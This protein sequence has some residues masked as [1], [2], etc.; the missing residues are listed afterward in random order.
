MFSHIQNT[1]TQYNL[2]PYEKRIDQAKNRADL[3]DHFEDEDL[4]MTVA[5]DM[6]LLDSYDE[7]ID[8]LELYLENRAKVHDAATFYLL[9]SIPGIGKILSLTI[10]YEIHEISRFPS[11]GE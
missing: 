9:R 11:V 10:L 7:T 3:L 4:Q 8:E 1:I 2:P 5:A 6:V